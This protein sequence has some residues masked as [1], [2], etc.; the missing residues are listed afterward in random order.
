MM[1]SSLLPIHISLHIVKKGVE[2]R[3]REEVIGEVREEKK[4]NQIQRIEENKGK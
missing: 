4:V 1:T 3:K 2:E